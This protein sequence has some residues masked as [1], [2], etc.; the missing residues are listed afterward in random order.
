MKK[1]WQKEIKQ[2][3]NGEKK[4]KRG[5]IWGLEKKM[6]KKSNKKER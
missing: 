5:K 4:L 3:T 1:E 6:K 2:E